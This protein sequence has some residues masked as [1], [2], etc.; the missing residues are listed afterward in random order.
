MAFT[1]SCVL[2]SRS[3]CILKNYCCLHRSS[4]EDLC[5]LLNNQGT[6]RLVIKHLNC[7]LTVS[8]YLTHTKCIQR[9]NQS[10]D[11]H[12]EQIMFHI[13]SWAN[14]VMNMALLLANS[15]GAMAMLTQH[16]PC[17]AF[18]GNQGDYYWGRL[19]NSSSK[20]P[21]DDSRGDSSQVV[22]NFIA[23]S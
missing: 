15:W 22:G 10:L 12:K 3:W 23:L 6:P 17:L 1:V 4:E 11:F 19:L 5:T 21:I 16:S 14:G 2:P 18:L 13:G 8:S 20:F 7:C 9:E